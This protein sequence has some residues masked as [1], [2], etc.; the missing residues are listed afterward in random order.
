MMINIYDNIHIWRDKVPVIFNK[1]IKMGDYVAKMKIQSVPPNA[2][3]PD[4]F[5]INFILLRLADFERVLLVD[6]HAP[7]GYHMHANPSNP[8]ERVTLE[9]S[10]PFEAL[11]IFVKKAKEIS[12]EE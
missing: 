4:G 5:K 9:V 3:R 7:F 2:N 12:N 10:S 6:N 11:D 8:K 1:S